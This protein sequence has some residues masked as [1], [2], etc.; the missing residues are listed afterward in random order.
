MLTNILA[1]I[2]VLIFTVLAAIHVYWLFGG[3]WGI[4]QVIP[5]KE[6]E[7]SA[8]VIPKFATAIVALVLFVFAL[9][10]LI[11]SG[12]LQLQEPHWIVHY[13]CWIIPSIFML[14]AIGDFKYVGFFKQIKHTKFAKADS[15]WFVPLCLTI[16]I[17]GI[18][19]QLIKV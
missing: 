13:G 15:K 1:I 17:F 5:T 7:M 18:L 2:L 8:L 12:L 16:A 4:E 9:I 6:N 11:T 19:I 10:Y 3:T 14:R